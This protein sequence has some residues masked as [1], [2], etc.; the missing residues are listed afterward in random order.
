V[1]TSPHPPAPAPDGGYDGY[2]GYKSI[3]LRRFPYVTAAVLVGTAL[4]NLVQFVVPG[5]LEHIQRTPAGLH[6][7]WWR[8]ATSLFG[9]DGGVFGTL[10]NLAFLA[11]IGA[12]AEQV[13]RPPKWLVCYFGAGLVTQFVAYAWQPYGAGNSVAVCGLA[14]ALIVA[15]WRGRPVPPISS[16]VVLLWCGVLLATVWW[17]LVFI[18]VAAAALA[19]HV[20]TDRQAAV[21]ALTAAVALTALRNIHGAALLTGVALGVLGVFAG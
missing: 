2:S 16:M 4:V 11:V 14:G 17:P 3:G 19:Q 5:T 10:S 9:Q 13:L 21:V 6:G 12:L 15:L 20:F 7:D 18:G 8:T 1:N